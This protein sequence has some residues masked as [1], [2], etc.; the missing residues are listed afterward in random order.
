MTS[1]ERVRRA[2]RYDHPDMMPVEIHGSP[3]GLHEHGE[4][5]AELFRRYPSD[6]GDLSGISVQHPAPEA[7]D[8]C[9]RYHEFRVDEWGV[10]WEHTIYGA[11]GI[12]RRRP[13]DDLA[14]LATFKAPPAPPTSGPEFDEA[15]RKAD[16][17][18][19]RFYLWGCG[20]DIFETLRSLRRYEDVLVDIQEDTDEINH[21]ADIVTDYREA[22][23]RRALAL[24]ADG[25]V[26]GDD[27]GT[28][29]ALMVSLPTW[30]RFF[31]PRYERLM[32]PIRD[33]GLDIHFHS[34]GYVLPLLPD[35]AE[36][37]VNS[38]WPQLPLY[39]PTELAQTCRKL[40]LAVALHM[41][42]SHLMT[43][44]SPDDIR[45]KVSEVAAVFR[46]PEGGAW[47]Y[48]EIDGGFPWE[49]VVALFEAVWGNR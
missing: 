3:T 18:R 27:H 32:A 48:I 26:F 11:W 24:D 5:L 19:T 38:I 9:G 30:R 14:N 49:N 17:H 15:K 35:L 28:Q 4:K 13:L 44:G 1:R 40:G 22:Q 8:S 43:F 12:P 47:W 25:I 20:V 42:R 33:A 16:E 31:K 23:I 7:Y 41:D 34:C 39:D 45:R 36:L 6:F 2:I 29:G 46:R 21:I 37:G 10:E